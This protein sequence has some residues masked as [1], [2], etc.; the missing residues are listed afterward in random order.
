METSTSKPAA[1]KANNEV[2]DL[3]NAAKANAA[4][5]RT[6][7]STVKAEPKKAEKKEKTVTMAS[8][9][10]KIILAGGTFEKLVEAAQARSKKLGGSIRYNA[11]VIRAHIKYREIKNPKYLGELKQT[12]TGIVAKVKKVKKAA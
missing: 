6:K 9:L 11:A 3:L 2:T 4:K 1:E 8:E 10:D 5:V 12:E 7:G